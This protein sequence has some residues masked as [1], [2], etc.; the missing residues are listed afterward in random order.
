MRNQPAKDCKTRL[1]RGVWML[2]LAGLVVL[3]WPQ[4]QAQVVPY[5]PGQGSGVMKPGGSGVMFG[6]QKNPNAPL[7]ALLKSQSRLSLLAIQDGNKPLHGVF[8]LE[9]SINQRGDVTL[10]LDLS[11]VDT[12]DAVRD[13]TIAEVLFGASPN[14]KTT[15]L[16][17]LS[18]GGATLNRVKKGEAFSEKLKGTLLLNNQKQPFSA[19]VFFSPVKTGGLRVLSMEPVELNPAHWG[20]DKNL[21]AL[22]KATGAVSLARPVLVTFDLVWR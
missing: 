1:R 8:S 3:P 11:S 14:K 15:A 10:T 20:L 12:G 4:T 2:L 17:S 7:Y 13:K 22:L 9:G 21:D 5:K 19:T 16:V 18:L 6:G